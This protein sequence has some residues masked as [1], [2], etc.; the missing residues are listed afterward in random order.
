MITDNSD[1]AR[2]TGPGAYLDRLPIGRRP[3]LRTDGVQAWDIFP[4]EGELRVKVLDEPVLPE[5]PRQGEAG[6]EECDQCARPD[7]DFLWTDEHW[8]LSGTDRPAGLP[9]MVLLQPRD[10]HDLADLPP[11][12]AAELGAMLQRTE[13]AVLSLGGIARVHIDKWGDGAAHLHF[14]LIARPEGMAQLRGACLPLWNDALPPVPA[15][16][17]ARTGRLIAAAMA[18]GGGTAQV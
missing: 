13:R 9:A 11:A 5:P 18:A 8:R 6:A 15:E 16:E 7:S 12:R 1:P 14:W 17:W 10:H 2:A 3:Q 4:F